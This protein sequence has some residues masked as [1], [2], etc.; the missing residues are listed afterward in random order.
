MNVFLDLQRVERSVNMKP[1]NTI[2][3]EIGEESDGVIEN[4]DRRLIQYSEI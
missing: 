4:L 3:L 2:L 1:K